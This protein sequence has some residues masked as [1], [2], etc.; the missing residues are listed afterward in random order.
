MHHLCTTCAPRQSGRLHGLLGWLCG[1]AFI[2]CLE[3]GQNSYRIVAN[4]FFT[5]KDPILSRVSLVSFGAQWTAF[6][7]PFR[8]F[9][10]TGTGSRSG[11]TSYRRSPSRALGLQM[12]NTTRRSVHGSS[13]LDGSQW[14]LVFA[15]HL[16][17]PCDGRSA[18]WTWRAFI[19]Q[20]MS[21]CSVGF[22]ASGAVSQYQRSFVFCTRHHIL[23]HCGACLSSWHFATPTQLG[24]SNSCRCLSSFAHLSW[25]SKFSLFSFLLFWDF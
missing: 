21:C 22:T 1:V 7:S 14:F 25:I 13:L 5:P 9:A 18:F 24:R 16:I 20:T 2:L 6:V 15:R 3:T 12:W 19:N 17:C 10:C 11:L 8:R 23:V 4:L